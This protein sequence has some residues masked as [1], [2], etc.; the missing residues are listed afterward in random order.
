MD[1]GL[2]LFRKNKST[3]GSRVARCFIGL[4]GNLGDSTG[5]IN[6]AVKMLDDTE[7]VF[8]ETLSRIIRTKPLG[9]EDQPDYFNAV[10]ALNTSMPAEKLH[11]RLSM[12]EKAL[13]RVRTED[14]WAARTI[15]LDLLLY[16]DKIIDS[17]G[18]NVP[19]SSMH[20]RTFVLDGMCEI[21]PDFIHPTLRRTMRE[22]KERLNGGDFLIEKDR[23]RLISVAGVIGCGKT[24]LATGLVK[25]LGSKLL[26]EA[27]D[28]NPYLARV[29]DGQKELALD[30]QLFFLKSRVEQIGRGELTPGMIAVTDYVFDKEIIYAR[31]TLNNEQYDR[32]MAEYRSAAGKVV[33]P[34]L[35][36]YLSTEPEKC[37]ERI[38]CRN[39]P[40]EQKIE[41]STLEHL[42]EEYE[43]MFADWRKS[44]VI[45]PEPYEFDSR[46]D[47]DIT[48]LAEESVYY[49]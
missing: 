41:L 46:K 18:L 8:V 23:P 31:L 11:Q 24:T 38:R 22:L 19:H 12:T 26:R 16:G 25:S 7:G 33:E 40:Y 4:G 44:P 32:Y 30:S 39:R 5:Y 35:V 27:Y 47:E 17:P 15:D 9:V 10:V 48:K 14:K 3:A 21:A 36:I 2:N 37:L 6:R 43:K 28:K 1:K 49:I 20:L 34:S 13:G 42:Y 29:Y 45:T